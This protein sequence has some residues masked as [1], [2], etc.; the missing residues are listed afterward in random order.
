MSD[1]N[2][3]AALLSAVARRLGIDG[4]V[5][6]DE[7]GSCVLRLEDSLVSISC[8]PAGTQLMLAVFVTVL[9]KPAPQNALELLLEANA[10]MKESAG[11]AFALDLDKGW[12]LLH[13]N[14]IADALEENVLYDV[15]THLVETALMMRARI[16][17]MLLASTPS[18]SD[19]NLE[20][21][22]LLSS[23]ALAV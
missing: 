10:F 13:R 14:L 15:I 3:Y 17:E 16:D 7:S 1:M 23:A 20:F 11:G 4:E 8:P 12:V 18:K 5:R 19:Q 21:D 6:A 2:R 22:S 9:P